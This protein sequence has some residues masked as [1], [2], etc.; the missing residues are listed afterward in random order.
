MTDTTIRGPLTEDEIESLGQRK[1][2]GYARESDT[3]VHVYSFSRHTLVDFAR[4]IESAST[5]RATAVE[6]ERCAV[7]AEDLARN[8]AADYAK[9]KF[10]DF[11]IAVGDAIRRGGT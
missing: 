8:T 5:E 10:V 2:S 1:A 7:A 11:R 4:A 6:R 3:S 9:W